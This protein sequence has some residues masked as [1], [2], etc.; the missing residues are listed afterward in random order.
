MERESFEDED[1]AKVLNDGFISIKV[2]REERAD[3]DSI[4]MSI[5]QALTGRGGWPLTIIMTPDKKPFFAGTYFPKEDRMGMRGIITVLT[6]VDNGWKYKKEDLIKS[7]ENILNVVNNSQGYEEE[8]FNE[9][10]FETAYNEFNSDFDIRHGG[11][12]GAPKFPTPH[13]IYF[14]LRYY[15]VTKNRSALNMALTTLDSMYKGGLYDHIG[16]GFT[17]YSTDNRWLVP[18]FEKMLYDNALLAIAYLEAYSITKDKLYGRVAEEIFTYVLNR[19]T[20]EDGGF[21]SAEDADS[22]GEEGK[23]YVWTKK[24]VIDILGEDEGERCCK[25]FDITEKG[26]FEGKSIPNLI[27]N[28]YSEDENILKEWKE[29]L[30]NYR[31]KRVHP[32]KDDKILT[33]WNGLMIAAMALGGKILKN[34]KYTKAAEKAVDFIFKNLID[35]EGNLLA[36]YREGEAAYVAYVDDYSFLT[37][38]LLELYET[39]YKEEYL[40]KALNLSKDLV[41]YFW[42]EENGGLFLY[43]SHGEELIM[44]PKEI[45]DGATPSGNSVSALNFLRLGRLTDEYKLEEKGSKILKSFSKDINSYPRAYSFSLISLLFYKNPTRNIVVMA[46]DRDEKTKEIIDLINEE[47][48]PFNLSIFYSKKSKLSETIESLKSYEIIDGKPTVFV[49]ENFSCMEPITDI[50]DLKKILHRK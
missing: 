49:C 8:E 36:R 46:E 40:N 20:S 17:R 11:F 6:S 35:R 38:G 19:M 1:V 4:Y 28:I 22:E 14:L 27:K 32:Y 24:E 23:F 30:F 41:K 21:Y 43:G 48:N 10:I 29:K 2:D 26:N 12:G 37:W 5:C 33:S 7:S 44:R 25:Y 50:E 9:D 18:H 39:T 31:E 13:N 47:F 16:Y 3:I 42:D 45:Y 15:H 34:N